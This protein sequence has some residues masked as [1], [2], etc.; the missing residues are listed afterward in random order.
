MQKT[1]HTQSNRSHLFTPCMETDAILQNHFKLVAFYFLN[2]DLTYFNISNLSPT[3][4]L[5]FKGENSR[6]QRGFTPPVFASRLFWGG[7]LI[8]SSLLLT[9]GP[10]RGLHFRHVGQRAR[11][12]V[13][14]PELPGLGLE[15][16]SSV[17]TAGGAH[18]STNTP[19]Q[20]RNKWL[21]LISLFCCNLWST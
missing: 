5:V 6:R 14:P 21:Y 17:E 8:F 11:C 20:R 3:P 19:S 13:R 4:R 18:S 1:K 7:Y 9:L 15:K 10:T 2:S 12:E 16:A